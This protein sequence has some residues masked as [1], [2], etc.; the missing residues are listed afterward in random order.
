M[1]IDGPTERYNHVTIDIFVKSVHV[2][3][4]KIIVLFNY[5]DSE[6]CISLD[7]LGD[8]EKSRTLKISVRL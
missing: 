8:K 3:D 7:E 2:C 5:K 6:K 4:D 1:K